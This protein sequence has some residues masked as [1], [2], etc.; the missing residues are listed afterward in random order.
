M[1]ERRLCCCVGAADAVCL[2]KEIK[3]NGV[4]G[5]QLFYPRVRCSLCS[6]ETKYSDWVL[7]PLLIA[8]RRKYGRLSSVSKPCLIVFC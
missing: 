4:Y 3:Y 8:L 5:S 7:D 1:L 6:I 2:L